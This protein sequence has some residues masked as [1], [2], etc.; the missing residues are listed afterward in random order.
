MAHIRINEAIAQATIKGI[1]VRKKEIAARLYP[2]VSTATQQVNFTNICRGRT[3][4]I[5]AE[6]VA[7]ICEMTDCTPNFLFGHE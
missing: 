2:D 4:R 5:T 1:K 7:I 3:K 6:Q